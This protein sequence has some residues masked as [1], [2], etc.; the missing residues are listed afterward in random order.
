MPVGH[1]VV[2]KFTHF[3]QV[4]DRGIDPE[5]M[6][7]LGSTNALGTPWVLGAPKTT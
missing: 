7:G 2:L 4:K 1:E 5:R 3:V 6:Q